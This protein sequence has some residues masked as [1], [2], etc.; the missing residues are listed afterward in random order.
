MWL[1]SKLFL[2]AA[3]GVG[4]YLIYDKIMAQKQAGYNLKYD[5]SQVRYN[6]STLIQSNFDLG[7]KIINNS[8]EQLSFDSFNGNLN[9]KGRSIADITMDGAGKGITIKANDSTPVTVPVTI[10]HLSTLVSASDI[11]QK[12]LNRQPVTDLVLTG[13]LHVGPL[14]LPIE[15]NMSFLFS[16]NTNTT[17]PVSG[18]NGCACAGMGVLN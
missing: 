18:I 11:V 7:L 3:L 15:K 10:N 4:G 2:Y 17:Q 1:K 5:V 8:S 13:T 9:Y 14:S 12:I 6:G 16:N